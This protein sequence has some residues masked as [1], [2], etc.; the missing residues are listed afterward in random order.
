M[1]ANVRSPQPAAAQARQLRPDLG[2]IGLARGPACDERLACLEH[3]RLDFLPGH[4]QD[5]P[6]LFVAKRV[7]LGEDQRCALIVR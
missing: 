5:V 7:E 4:A 6:D 2:A 3:E 1:P